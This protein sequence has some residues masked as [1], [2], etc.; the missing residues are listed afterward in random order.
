MEQ[1]LDWG[2]FIGQGIV[3]LVTGIV[4]TGLI[5]VKLLKPSFLFIKKEHEL[6]LLTVLVSG[7]L[8]GYGL[9][10][11][12]QTAQ[13]NSQ[14]K[15]INTELAKQRG[16]IET[17]LGGQPLE[18]KE[19]IYDIVAES[20]ST[21]RERIR[22]VLLETRPR[23]PDKV[24]AVLADRLQHEVTYEIVVVLNPKDRS[25]EFERSH[26]ELWQVLKERKVKDPRYFLFVLE[27]D[28]QICFDTLI[29]DE[30]DVGIAFTRSERQKEL[31][32]A[33]MFRNSP[34]MAKKFADWFDRVIKPQS[35]PFEKWK[36]SRTGNM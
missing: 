26:T 10:H 35:I 2:I 16:M 23:I 30:K 6:S 31:E 21:A 7:L 8:T 36:E 28:K 9:N 3:P 33:I 15:N 24:L 14:L 29:V 34:D 32:N 13:V 22:V 11:M 4:V 17:S 27:T 18:K 5:L 19:E 20:I 12:S 1:A 25:G